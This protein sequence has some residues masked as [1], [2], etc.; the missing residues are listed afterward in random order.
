MKVQVTRVVQPVQELG[1]EVSA[2]NSTAALV[3]DDDFAREKSSVSKMSYN[4][5]VL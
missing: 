3:L 1:E 5:Q 4:R 2:G